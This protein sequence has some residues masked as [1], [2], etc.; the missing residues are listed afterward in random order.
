M[1]LQR[2]CGL[3]LGTDTIKIRDKSGKKFLYSRNVIALRDNGSVLAYGDAAYG[4]YEKQPLTV[5]VVWPMANGV[6]ANLTEMDILLDNLIHRYGGASS[7]LIAVPTEITQV[8]KR[9]FFQVMKGQIQAGR[10][11]LLEKGLADAVSAS[12]PVLSSR[13]HMVVN[14]GADTTEISVISS[15]KVILGQTL[16]TGGRRMDADIAT[17][18]RRKFNLSIGQKTAESLKNNLAFMINGP[19]LEQK[20]FGIH[21]LSGLPKSE[22]IPSLAVSVAIIDTVDSIVESINSI[23]NRIPPQLMKDISREGIYLSGGVSMIL[24]L[25]EYIRRE[26]GIPLHHVQDPKYSTIRGLVEVMNNKDLKALTY[27]LNDLAAMR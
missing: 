8:E 12:L 6:I 19:R 14:I 1:L 3:D 25:P 4:V 24:N 18:V 13:G 23:Y 15:G 7:L 21:T 10:I 16:K 2:A 27:T 11:R 9:A 17:M 20:V 22:V 26:I 5:N